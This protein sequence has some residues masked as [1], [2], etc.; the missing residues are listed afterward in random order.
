MQPDVRIFTDSN[1]PFGGSARL[2]LVTYWFLKFSAKRR[3][4]CTRLAPKSANRTTDVM[5]Y[6]AGADI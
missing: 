5:V 1:D 3:R 4:V 6:E 2:A